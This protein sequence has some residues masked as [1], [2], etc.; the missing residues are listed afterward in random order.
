LGA[1]LGLLL[2]L[3]LLF[4]EGATVVVEEGWALAASAARALGLRVATTWERGVRKKER[5]KN[6]SCE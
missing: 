5:R 4:L 6:V 3:L 1:A 2:S